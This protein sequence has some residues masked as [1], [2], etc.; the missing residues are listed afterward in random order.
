MNQ[1]DFNLYQVTTTLYA[2]SHQVIKFAQDQLSKI[3]SKDISGKALAMKKELNDL[4]ATET[5][6]EDMF[7]KI[8]EGIE[9]KYFNV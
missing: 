4:I 8:K 1:E 9:S 6:R 5:K 7:R 2:Q 3:S